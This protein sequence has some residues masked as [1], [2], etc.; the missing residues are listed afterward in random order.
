MEVSV[1]AQ[2]R[3]VVAAVGF[4]IFLGLLYD[5][6]RILFV[7]F[8]W[9]G[10]GQV[11][12]C[13]RHFSF[14][15]LSAGTLCRETKKGTRRVRNAAIFLRDVGF[16]LVVGILFSVFVYWQNDGIFRWYLLFGTGLG[17]AAY[18]ATIGRLVLFS[19][20]TIAFFLH[21]LAAYLFLF[22]RVPAL[23]LFRAVRRGL[24]C[25]FRFLYR[26]LQRGWLVFYSPH[27]KA[28]RLSA[29]NAFGAAADAGNA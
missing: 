25:V 21:V 10:S 11:P 27:A 22:V 17:F 13:L 8:G 2:L 14:P 1:L 16:M 7:F 20:A 3:S 4:G 26:S 24:F 19:S 9:E 6:G 5:V 15:L 23:W 12:T 29:I 18:A 28:A